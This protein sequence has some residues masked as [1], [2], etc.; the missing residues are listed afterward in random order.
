MDIEN[1]VGLSVVIP[2]FNECEVLP[3]LISRLLELGD[4]VDFPIEF[5]LVDGC[6]TDD[7]AKILKELLNNLDEDRFSCVLVNEREVTAS[8]F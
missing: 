8:I 6:S 4:Q 5:I 1:N 3:F 7:S 2:I